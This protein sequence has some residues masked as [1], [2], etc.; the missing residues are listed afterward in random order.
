MTIPATA[1]RPTRQLMSG[2]IVL[3]AL[4]A[5][6]IG[7]LLV[8]SLLYPKL[9]FETLLGHEG[10]STWQVRAALRAIMIVGLAGAYVAYRVLGELRAMVETVRAGDMFIPGN[11]RRLQAVAWWVLA[12]E[13]LR[14]LVGAIVWGASRYLPVIDDID[15]GFSFAPWLSVLLLFVLARVFDEGTRMRADLDGTV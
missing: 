14:L 10:A 9:V 4:Y 11:V 6:A 2:L 3:N 12:G 1:L 8:A 15:V 5:F 13:C 7:V